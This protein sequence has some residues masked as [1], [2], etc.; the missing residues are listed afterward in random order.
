MAKKVI[1]D[2]EAREALKVGV[3]ILANA[4][5]VTLGPKGRNVVLGRPFG[6]PAITKDGVSIAREVILED[7]VQNQGAQ[8]V[9]E[10]AQNTATQAG[11]GT[12]TSIVLAQSIVSEGIKNIAAGANPMEVKN[13]IEMAVKAVVD[14]LKT[15]SQSIGDD[16]EKIKHVATISSNNDKL[17][18][19][20]IAEAMSSVG[21]DGVITVEESPTN[22]TNVK[23]VEGMQFNCGML[24]P[25]FAT[26]DIKTEAI[27]E[28]PVI[29]LF[30]GKIENAKD[31]IPML[32][33]HLGNSNQPI[34]IIAN[35]VEG[36]ALPT[37]II[38]KIKGN[39]KVIAVKSFGFGSNR[40]EVLEDIALLTGAKL[41]SDDGEIKLEKA[42]LTCLGTAAKII[43][44]LDST[45]I[46]DG[47]GLKMDIENRVKHLKEKLSKATDD[48]L[49][50]SLKYRLAKLSGGVAIL[51]VGALSVMEMREKMDRIDDA[52]KAT[53]AAVEEGIV[54]GGGVAFIRAVAAL[55][56]LVGENSDQ[57]TGI[58]IIRKAI[59]EPL[60]Q[61]CKNAG[62]EGSVIINKIKEGKG[63]FG[64]NARSGEFENLI[65]AGV[66]DP[67][68]VSRVAL[69]NAA[70]VS[71]LILTTEALMYDTVP[72]V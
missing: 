29:L 57:E 26:D 4:V 36:D 47:G 46:I 45:T 37:L 39:V 71:A 68:K 49:I 14:N 8:M 15:Q 60:R 42:D 21:N 41:I 40:T 13:G 72:Q 33:K 58:S 1:Y 25:K 35:E 64:Y 59:E 23:L 67:A 20:L 7:P 65:E 62:V 44:T 56:T 12:T 48:H 61:I 28:K 70:S 69:E 54:A 34:L 9:K 11:D 18:G 32:E 6:P 66:I 52:L 53:R 43:V 16:V 22:E 51:N 63:D 17:I 19:S 50:T 2:I 10:V 5:K 55:N 3:D 31:I 24:S 27:Y 38:N 30:D